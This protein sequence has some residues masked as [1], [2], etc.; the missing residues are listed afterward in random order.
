MIYNSDTL[1]ALSELIKEL[2]NDLDIK[3]ELEFDDTFKCR[4]GMY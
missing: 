2:K 3:I 1:E 4:I